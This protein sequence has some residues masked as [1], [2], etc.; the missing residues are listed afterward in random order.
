MDSNKRHIWA[1]IG[2]VLFMVLIFLLLW[3]VR[4]TSIKPE[5]EEVEIE[6]VDMEEMEEPAMRG[7][8]YAEEETNPAPAAPASPAQEVAT[9]PNPGSAPE[10]IVSEE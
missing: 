7:S 5:T 8:A 6:F 9:D 1:S 3:F 4:L 10:H 2:T